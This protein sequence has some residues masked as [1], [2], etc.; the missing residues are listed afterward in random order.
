MKLVLTDTRIKYCNTPTK[1]YTC[2]YCGRE[3]VR[4]ISV[5]NAECWE[6]KIKNKKR[7]AQISYRRKKKR[8]EMRD[9]QR[10]TH[11]KKK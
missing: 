11:L 9:A 4:V 6:C 5:K 2:H 7:Y 3:V 10:F 8:E 1:P